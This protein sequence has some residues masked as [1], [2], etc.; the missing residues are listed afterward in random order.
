[1]PL[2]IRFVYGCMS[3]RVLNCEAPLE[4]IH[5]KKIQEKFQDL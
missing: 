5:H 3:G 1:M 4:I 2:L